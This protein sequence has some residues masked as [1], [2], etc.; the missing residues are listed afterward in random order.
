LDRR[1][2]KIAVPLGP[3]AADVPLDLQ[4]AFDR[5]WDEGAYPEILRYEG[6]PPGPISEDEVQWCRERIATGGIVEVK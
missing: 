6:R 5:C 4:S 3:D 1:L 2:P